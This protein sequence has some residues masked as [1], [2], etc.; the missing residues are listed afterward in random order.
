MRNRPAGE[1]PSFYHPFVRF[2]FGVQTL[3]PLLQK[4]DA[5]GSTPLFLRQ[6]VRQSDVY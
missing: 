6:P 5:N 2:S 1:K 3:L 4:P